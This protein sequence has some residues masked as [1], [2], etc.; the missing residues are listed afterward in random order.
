[1]GLWDWI[2]ESIIGPRHSDESRRARGHASD[3]ATCVAEPDIFRQPRRERSKSATEEQESEPWWEPQ[4][5]TATDLEPPRAPELTAEA[6]A[7]QNLLVSQF[8]GHQ[9]DLPPLPGVAERVLC[10]LGDPKYDAASLTDVIAEDQVIAAAV[11]RMANSALFAA[12]TKISSLQ[13]AV[14]RIGSNAVRT[15]MM[16]QAF[17][18]AAFQ[19][20]GGDNEFTRMIW[21]RALA[22]GVISRVLGP[23]AGVNAE[24]AFVAGL[25]ADIGNVIVLREVQKQQHVLEYT[26]DIDT[27]EYFCSECHQEFGELVAEA[28]KLPSDLKALI[29]DHHATPQPGDSLRAHRLILQLSEMVNSM[30]GFGRPAAYRLLESRPVR[31]LRLAERKAFQECLVDLPGFLDLNMPSLSL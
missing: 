5:A 2:I 21:E 24:E 1:M 13:N 23:L 3:A 17:R 10:C 7:L 26:I 28:W 30:I 12:V 18:A 6:R 20:K 22:N 19:R 25:L 15:L 29:A 16:H 4:D 8:D 27:F 9:L 14:T 11:L 31:E